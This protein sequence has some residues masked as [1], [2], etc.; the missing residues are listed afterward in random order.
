[1]MTMAS[2][3]TTVGHLFQSVA[4]LFLLFTT[5]ISGHGKQEKWRKR[6]MPDGTEAHDTLG[7]ESSHDLTYAP[8][9]KVTYAL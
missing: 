4:V 8:D 1:M 5:A 2:Q 3:A 6:L 7:G 9:P